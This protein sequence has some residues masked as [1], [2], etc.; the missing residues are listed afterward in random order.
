[1]AVAR[2]ARGLINGERH[3]WSKLGFGKWVCHW[4]GI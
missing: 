4:G 3:E 1:M 2:R